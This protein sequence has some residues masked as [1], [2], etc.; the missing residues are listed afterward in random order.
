MVWRHAW[1]VLIALACACGRIHFG[2]LRERADGALSGDPD[3]VV[4][5][6]SMGDAAFSNANRAFVTSIGYPLSTIGSI[7][8]ANMLCAERAA[9]GG[10]AGTFVAFLSSTTID[11]RDQ[12]AGARGWVRVDG[13]PVA[14]T[15]DDLLNGRLIHPI[16]AD[17]LGQQVGNGAGV[18]LVITGTGTDGRYDPVGS[19]SDF[20]STTGVIRS[21]E[22][23]RTSQAAF[24][25]SIVVQCDGVS[26]LYCFG[27]D[28]STPIA[29]APQTGRLAFVASASFP[30]GT[31]IGAADVLCQS[32][33]DGAGRPGMFRAFMANSSTT[34]ASRFSA[35]G[36]T[37]VRVDGLPVAPTAAQVLAGGFE[38][39][40]RLQVDG[41]PYADLIYFGAS[42]T[43][44]TSAT[45]HCLDWTSTVDTYT[46]GLADHAYIGAYN[47]GARTCSIPARTYCLEQ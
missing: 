47:V 16:V 19:C 35:S 23:Y 43:T 3:G 30:M 37:W 10:H 38:I 39:P 15:V 24:T 8:N 21:G 26:R 22:F 36:A 27:V 33:A 34:A 13:K 42:T 29:L 9:A 41:T 45:G 6:D 40:V 14:D 20:T 4:S 17:E 32:D 5:G 28:R 25:S 7:A 1:P 2:P 31:G 11:A 46:Y 44:S 18:N 12:L